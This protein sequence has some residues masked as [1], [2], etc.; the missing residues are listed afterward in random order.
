M[1]T[2]IANGYRW[3]ALADGVAHAHRTRGRAVRTLC[4]L[5]AIDERYARPPVVRCP[6]C[7]EVARL[8]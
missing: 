4:D 2:V 3:I 7:M 5:P 6:R 1:T 8:D